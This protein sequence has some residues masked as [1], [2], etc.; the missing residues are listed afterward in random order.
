[1]GGAVATTGACFAANLRDL[2]SAP[3]GEITYQRPWAPCP[4]VS[5]AALSETNVYIGRPLIVTCRLP[6]LVEIEPMTPLIPETCGLS[7][8]ESI[9]GQRAEHAPVQE[10]TP[11]FALSR[12]KK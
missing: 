6:F 11:D 4:F 2:I 9:A 8:V 1:M 3:V 7:P 12:S 10:L 5:P